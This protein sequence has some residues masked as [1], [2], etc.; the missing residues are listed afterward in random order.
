MFVLT[1]RQQLN[2]GQCASQKQEQKDETKQVYMKS[3]KTPSWLTYV[4]LYYILYYPLLYTYVFVGFEI[5][6]PIYPMWKSKLV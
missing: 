6:I 3:A 5:G 4:E 2:F 1:W